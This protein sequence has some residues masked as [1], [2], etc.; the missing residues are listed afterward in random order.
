MYINVFDSM[1]IFDQQ[2]ICRFLSG[3][4]SHHTGIFPWLPEGPEPERKSLKALS[5]TFIKPLFVAMPFVHI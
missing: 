4:M 2:V 5:C 3:I 1:E